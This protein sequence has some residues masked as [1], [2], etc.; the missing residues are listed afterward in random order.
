MPQKKSKN[1]RVRPANRRAKSRNKSRTARAPTKNV[2]PSVSFS[3]KETLP[4]FPASKL[5][6]QQLYYDSGLA[7]NGSSG[8]LARYVFTA[9]GA[10]DPDITGTGHQPIGFDQMMVFYEQFVV[11][12]SKI[13]ITCWSTAPTPC[14][15]AIS[16]APDAT[17]AAS[18]SGLVE[19]GLTV[20]DWCGN[21]PTNGMF[22]GTCTLELTCD[23]AKYFGRS[24]ASLISGAEF[25]GT[26]AANPVEQVYFQ[27]QTWNPASAITTGIL[28]DVLISYDI[29]YYEPRKTGSSFWHGAL[30]ALKMQFDPGEELVGGGLAKTRGPEPERK[31]PRGCLGS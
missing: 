21:A 25:Y 2:G 29:Y 3:L 4:I 16:L 14:R 8:V 9:N 5:V 20:M 13:K 27:V 11:V 22:K 30:D 17:A 19:N 1:Q 28:F 18:I 15:V 31:T 23:V 26:A 7:I 10:Y 6:T 12:R 24:R